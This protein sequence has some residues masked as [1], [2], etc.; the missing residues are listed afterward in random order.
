[1][2]LIVDQL[3]T[4]GVIS[5]EASFKEADFNRLAEN[6]WL[7]RVQYHAQCAHLIAHLNTSN[8][9]IHD[10]NTKQTIQATLKLATLLEALHERLNELP[11]KTKFSQDKAILENLLDIPPN[12]SDF[13]GLIQNTTFYA[14]TTRLFIGNIRR[15]CLAL[16]TFPETFDCDLT[17]ISQLSAFLAP[18]VTLAGFLVYL[19]RTIVNSIVL[20][21][22]CAETPVIPLAS[23]FQAHAE[24]ND[25]LFNL[26]NDFPSVISGTLSVFIFTA[27]TAW[28]GA[29]VTVAVK[30]C[31]VIF[32]MIKNYYDV[33]RLKNMRAQYDEHANNLS[34]ID[35]AYL[36]YLD[37]SIAYIQ[38][39][40][41]INTVMHSLLLLCLTAFIPPIMMLHPAIPILAVSLAIALISLRFAEFRD[42]W[43]NKPAPQDDLGSSHLNRFFPQSD[44]ST[45][46]APPL[47]MRETP[48]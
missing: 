25:R 22:Q 36:A 21:I 12:I 20:V 27:S 30:L 15:I 5:R 40:R 47:T 41:N 8:A 19:P 13:P 3:D 23:R 14:D 48:V 32:S 6:A 38:V 18:I 17:W 33:S 34:E 31:E 4:Q 37:K 28:L 42:F 24:I 7:W 39:T 16:L 11:V 46:D 35:K 9:N 44:S 2:A 26:I 10:E 45:E 1:M 43:I 29:Y